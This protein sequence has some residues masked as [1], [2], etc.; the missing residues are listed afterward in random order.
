MLVF[1]Q[2]ESYH[3]HDPAEVM[4]AVGWGV[5]SQGGSHCLTAP[6]SSLNC[7]P[8]QGSWEN[9]SVWPLR[10]EVKNF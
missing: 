8:S 1:S 6:Q 4:T 9:A 5:R 2:S 7:A 3:L 10:P